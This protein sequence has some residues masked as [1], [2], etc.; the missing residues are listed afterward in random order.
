MRDISRCLTLRGDTGQGTQESTICPRILWQYL[1]QA[2]CPLCNIMIY[3][4]TT[5]QLLAIYGEN[6]TGQV[7]P[8]AML[9]FNDNS[10]I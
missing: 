8:L 6:S 7:Q 2:H 4:A 5:D 9:E 1:T 3:E 10:L